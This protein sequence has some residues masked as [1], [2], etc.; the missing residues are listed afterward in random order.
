MTK[1]NIHIINL[2]I[3]FDILEEIKSE[4]NFEIFHYEDTKKFLEFLQN[5]RVDNFL[6]L[7]KKINNQLKSI[8]SLDRKQIF[9]LSDSPISINKLI[10]NLNIQLIKLKYNQ[11]SQININDYNLNLNSRFFSKKTK[12]LKLT[13]KEIDIILFLSEKS[14]PQS[15]NI[16]QS[17]VWKYEVGL[18]THTVE[19]HIYRLRKKIKD[20]FND[21]NFIK[22]QDDGYTI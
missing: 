6:V 20:I 13:Q 4:L 1:Q 21:D 16:L 3:L 18:E 14:S 22:S 17:F 8:A 7:T 9:V 19:T 5:N 2:K 15:V 11:Q 10:E 12:Q